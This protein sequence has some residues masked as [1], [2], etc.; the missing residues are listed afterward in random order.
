MLELLLALLGVDEDDELEDFSGEEELELEL[1]KLM[2]CEE[3]EE[4]EL[5]IMI[6]RSSVSFTSTRHSLP[7]PA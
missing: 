5:S 1:L 4:D 2:L 6:T 7:I 3:L